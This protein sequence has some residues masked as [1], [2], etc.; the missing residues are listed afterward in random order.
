LTIKYNP[1]ADGKKDKIYNDNSVP[2]IRLAGEKENK[3]ESKLAKQV[4]PAHLELM[5]LLL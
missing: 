3:E 5:L 4:F 1:S 2:Y